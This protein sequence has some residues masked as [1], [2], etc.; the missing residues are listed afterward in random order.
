MDDIARHNQGHGRCFWSHSMC[1]QSLSSWS[2]AAVDSILP[3]API[4]AFLP[5]SSRGAKDA[6]LQKY[7]GL[8]IPR[9]IPQLIIIGNQWSNAVPFGRKILRQILS[10]VSDILQG[11]WTL[12]AHSSI[13]PNHIGFF[14]WP[15]RRYTILFQRVWLSAPGVSSFRVYL[16]PT[17]VSLETTPF[18]GSP[19]VMTSWD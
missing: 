4:W 5:I 17:V 16:S 12:V 10:K 3:Q 2:V 7:Q 6:C 15:I 13:L 11:K 9:Y 1:F 18:L 8:N 19:Y 14:L